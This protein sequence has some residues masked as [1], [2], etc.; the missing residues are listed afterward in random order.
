M[1]W[2]KVRQ[3]GLW[4]CLSSLNS[5]QEHTA[6]WMQLQT[7]DPLSIFRK[8]PCFTLSAILIYATEIRTFISNIL[9]F[10]LD[11]LSP[12]ICKLFH[13]I[14]KKG[15]WLIMKWVRHCFLHLII[16]KLTTSY[17]PDRLNT[18]KSEG[19]K[20]GLMIMHRN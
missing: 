10:L 12:T 4:G 11:T 13:V 5:N 19:A 9:S 14:R 8:F 16:C 1:W 7:V 15:S 3:G 20:P 2:F 6:V 18:W 17:G